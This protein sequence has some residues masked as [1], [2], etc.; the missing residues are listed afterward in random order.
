MFHDLRPG[1]GSL[2]IA[3]PST[4]TEDRKAPRSGSTSAAATPAVAVEVEVVVVVVVGGGG[5]G[6][7]TVVDAA[8]TS[9]GQTRNTPT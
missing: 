7:V 5:G 2:Q 4:R 3:E 8:C 6:I 1:R 9:Q